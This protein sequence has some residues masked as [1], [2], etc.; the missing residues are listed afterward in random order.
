[1]MTWQ[2]ALAVAAALFGAFIVWRVRP[3]FG[4]RRVTKAHRE[5][6]VA[7]RAKL[8]AAT[9]PEARALALCD[10][11]DAR[12]AMAGKATSALGY[13]LRA[14]RIAPASVEPIRRAAHAL[15]KKP[16]ALESLLWRRLGS[17][18]W[19]GEN[20]SA[21]VVALTELQRIYA[22]SVRNRSRAKALRSLLAALGAE[23][24]PPVPSAPAERG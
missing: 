9:S 10:V 22:G 18:E 1:M 16:R 2:L 23:V 7:A 8:E 19:T 13:Y 4:P 11:G 15:A 5:A 24:P 12:A 21:A 17:S 6:F 20:R 14:I 3:S